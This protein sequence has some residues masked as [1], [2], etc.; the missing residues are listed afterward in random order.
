MT[1]IVDVKNDIVSVQGNVD[2]LGDLA[3]GK[4][5]YIDMFKHHAKLFI[6]TLFLNQINI[7]MN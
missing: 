4:D 6:D 1:V 7:L 2:E 5:A 3:M